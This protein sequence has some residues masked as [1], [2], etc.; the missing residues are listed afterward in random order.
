LLIYSDNAVKWGKL[1]RHDHPTIL[2]S[3]KENKEDPK[4]ELVNLIKDMTKTAKKVTVCLVGY[5]NTGKSSIIS[6]FGKITNVNPSSV[7]KGLNEITIDKNIVMFDR[8]GF[9]FSKTDIGPLMPK[10][11]KDPA[12]LKNP[13]DIVKQVLEV[14]SKNA[15]LELYEIPE[16]DSADEFLNHIAKKHNYKIKVLVC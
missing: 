4:T 6:T 15:V 2:Y 14:L 9:L 5:P 8:P 13:D 7:L 10:T 1:L 3:A 12:D 11:A 16:F